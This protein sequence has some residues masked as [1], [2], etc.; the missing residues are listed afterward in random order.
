MLFL[1]LSLTVIAG[2]S[3]GWQLGLK[4]K[5]RF[6]NAAT[7]ATT[8]QLTSQ[9]G[10]ATS[11]PDH[12]PTRA[13]EEPEVTQDVEDSACSGAVVYEAEDQPVHVVSAE[14][15]ERIKHELAQKMG[16]CGSELGFDPHKVTLSDNVLWHAHQLGMTEDQLRSAVSHSTSW[17]R[18]ADSFR[19]K[20]EGFD[21]IVDI[22]QTMVLK[23]FP[24]DEHAATAATVKASRAQR[25]AVRKQ[26]KKKLKAGPSQR[27][28]LPSTS[29][30]MKKLLES[31]GFEVTLGKKHYKVTHPDQRGK[32][33]T[34]SCTPEDFRWSENFRS[35]M[36][37]VFGI[38]LRDVN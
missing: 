29:K 28:S 22:D 4:H 38:D 25:K 34:M 27:G 37:M 15:L 9:S 1:V 19:Y 2:Y 12:A 17:I 32:Q 5:R 30:E 3:L 14:E 8:E 6:I 33:I 31:R 18:E 11:E 35:K 16:V 7:R 26:R 24:S 13:G 10:K 36:R 20:A 21:F 23:V